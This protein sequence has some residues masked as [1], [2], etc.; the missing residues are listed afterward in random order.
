LSSGQADD[1]NAGDDR[2]VEFEALHHNE[3][4]RELAE[5]REPA[6]PQYRIQTDIAAR[7][8]NIGGCNFGH[9]GSLSA[10][11]PDHKFAYHA[12]GQ[13]RVIAKVLRLPSRWPNERPA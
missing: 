12:L 3:N 11:G 9:I 5:H 13:A 10:P 4:G 8:A 2:D 7:M 1:G 6:Q